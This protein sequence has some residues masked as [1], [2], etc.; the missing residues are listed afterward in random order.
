MLKVLVGYFPW[1]IFWTFSGLGDWVIGVLGA[2]LTTAV[3]VSWRWLKRKNVKAIELAALGFF[4]VH[5][6]ISLVLNASFL[7][8]AGLI[9]SHLV[10]AGM[11][12]GTILAGTPYTY[13]YIREDQPKA[14]WSEPIFL[15]ANKIISG[16][17]G[18][19]FLLNAGLGVFGMVYSNWQFLLNVIVINTLNL[20]GI[21]FSFLFP[22]WF[23][24][25]AIQRQI[26]A[27][28]PYKWP[29]PQFGSPT[30][31][32][33]EHDVIVVGS[34]IGGLTAAALLAKRGLKTAV[35]EQHFMH[36]GFCTS[37]ESSARVNGKQY[38]YIFDAAVHD[39]VGI[40][41]PGATHNLM[42]LLDIGESIDWKRMDH[43]YIFD[44]FHLRVPRDYKALA[45]KLGEIFPSEEEGIHA[46]FEEMR[47][48]VR[49]MYGSTKENGGVPGPPKTAEAMLDYPLKRP[50]AY[51]WLNRPFTSFL[52]AHI[53]DD[54]LKRLL[55][56]LTAYLSDDPRQLTAGAMAPVFQYYFDG[57]YYPCG[58]SGRIADALAGVIAQNKGQVSVS[59]PVKRIVIE[60]NR[61][62]GVELAKTG[63]IHH[64]S[65]VISNADLKHTFTELVGAEHL[66]RQF[67]EQISN[68]RPSTSVFMVFL[69]LDCI[70]N[71]EP[72]TMYNDFGIMIPSKVDPSLA[73][74][75]HS[76]MTLIKFIPQTEAGSWDRGAQDYKARKTAYADALIDKV[77]KLIP[78]LRSRI[79]YRQSASPSTVERFVWTDAGSIYGPVLD[80]A[81]PPM[82][83]PVQNLYLTGAGTFPGPGVEAV[84]ASGTRVADAI[85]RPAK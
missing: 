21:A 69:G 70:P 22:R 80:S 63:H 4:T 25:F 9:L 37:W 23:P 27:L 50:H 67:H 82:K 32:E 48:V 5:A 59:S 19:I 11:A 31:A 15:R 44:D 45:A 71:L 20:A 39:V 12:W 8:E 41:P 14:L 72:V 74:P 2:L 57:G 17:W 76:A 33:N 35:F 3:I 52:D 46:F 54:R 1:I 42:H 6:L 51:Y 66:P 38:K 43:E 75:G 85:Y 77:G 36:G 64:A 58:G 30:E 56:T 53:Q 60:N 73:P 18:G 49:E 13:Q 47:L 16:V 78:N 84:I 26:D 10:L 62:I 7:I 79:I 83:S 65:A 28:E 34:G 68:C 29:A 55:S 61:A 24:K 81:R 40:A